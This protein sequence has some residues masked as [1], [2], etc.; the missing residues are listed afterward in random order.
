MKA[1]SL[2]FLS[3]AALLAR[4]AIAGEYPGR[5]GWGAKESVFRVRCGISALE[6]PRDVD[7]GTAFGHK[8]GNVLSAYHVVEPC[9]KVTGRLKLTASDRSV[10]SAAVLISDAA[11][12]LVLLKPNEGFVK[13]PLAI[14]S[15]DQFTMG[16]QVTTWGFPNGYSGEV[17]LLTVG[18]LAGAVSDPNHPSIRR[19]IVNAAINKGNSGG[20]LLETDT[21][22][23]IG[24]VI[25]KLSP[26]TNESHSQLMA[27]SNNG[28]SEAKTLASAMIDIAQRAQL[29]IGHS[30]LTKDLRSFLQRGGIE[31]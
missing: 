25:Q 4:D 16:A 13:N 28:S 8:S 7:L 17:A 10:S 21:P 29:V 11:L 19:W 31:P 5:G 6:G 12:D 3:I 15:G 30:V 9:L 18:Y 2:I 1:L 23:I 14:A 22:S 20:P 26:L 24:M 27:I